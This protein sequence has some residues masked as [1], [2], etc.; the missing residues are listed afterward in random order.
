MVST[1][2][3]SCDESEEAKKSILPRIPVA[4]TVMK[5]TETA[6]GTKMQGHG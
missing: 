1:S 2:S 4:G 6:N 3:E 5:G